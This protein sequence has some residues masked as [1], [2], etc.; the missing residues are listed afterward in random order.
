MRPLA[1]DAARS[2]DH[3]CRRLRVTT[4]PND[5]SAA[6]Q[7]GRRTS[8]IESEPIRRRKLSHEVLD[9][10]LA[11][12]T[13][14]E[15]ARG[16]S[17]AVRARPD[18]PVRRRPSGRAR[19]VAGA[20]AHGPDRHHPRRAGTDR[21]THRADHDRPDGLSARASPVDL[22]DLARAAQG[23]AACSS[24]TG[25]VRAGRGACERGRHRPAAA[26][27]STSIEAAA[28][29]GRRP[30]PHR[31]EF[32][33]KDMAFHREIAAM[34]GQRDL[35]GPERGDVRV[36]GRVPH[37]ARPSAWGRAADH[38]GARGDLRADRRPRRRWVRPR[39]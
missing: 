35:R 17:P 20:G 3:T 22:A 34:T 38:R 1:C 25:M 7:D 16:R 28:R 21:G 26:A 10:L 37:R 19:G 32:L 36:A 31:D 6:E 23:G 24:R 18:E 27:G 5:R 8:M 29:C 15:L 30:G 12:I 11:R 4:A 14:G 39:R 2:Y 9:R 13:R 33:Q